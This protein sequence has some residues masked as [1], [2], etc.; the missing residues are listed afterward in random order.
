MNLICCRQMCQ[1][2]ISQSDLCAVVTD[3]LWHAVIM[4]IDIFETFISN[5]NDWL[6]SFW[7]LQKRRPLWRLQSFYLPAFLTA[8]VSSGL[9]VWFEG[10]NMLQWDSHGVKLPIS[11]WGAP[12]LD[13]H[14]ICSENGNV[15][16]T[17]TRVSVK[18]VFVTLSEVKW[19][20]GI[21]NQQPS[22]TQAKSQQTELFSQSCVL[23]IRLGMVAKN[24][25]HADCT[26][27][28]WKP[29]WCRTSEHENVEELGVN[30][31][32]S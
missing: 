12:F 4:E 8:E 24:Q 14:T 21:L 31:V 23:M 11:S 2:I 32:F 28:T 18:S 16:C 29:T 5:L 30:A 13:I 6:F 20:K 15:F 9:P 19:S 3:R 27:T 26:L 1:S 10:Y 25:S 22:G 17:L 7:C